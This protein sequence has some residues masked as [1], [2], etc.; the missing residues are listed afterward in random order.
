MPNSTI[1]HSLVRLALMVILPLIAAPVVSIQVAKAQEK[2]KLPLGLQGE[3]AFIPDDNPQTPEKIA[4]GK[5]FFWDKRWSAS[6]TVACV[7]C[8]QPDRGWTDPQQF[9]INFA[10][11]PTPR[12]APTIVN[13]LFSDVQL[14]TGLRASL[15]EQALK[16]LNRTDEKVVE[17]LGSIPAYQQ[18][19]RKI[20]GHDLE[21]IGVAKAIAAYVRTIVSGNSPYDRF[22]AGDKSALS[23]EAQRG[24]ALFEGKAGCVTCHVGFNFT[25][26]NYRNVGVGMDKPNPDLGRYTVT[27]NE[28]EKGAFKTPTLR[29]VARR[30]PYMHDGSEKTLEDLVAFY[31]RGGVNNPW[32]SS[33]IKPLKLTA[34]EQKDLVAFL[35]SL[36]GE[37]DPEVGKPP[38]LPQ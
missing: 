26:E 30:G 20:F 32:L 29:D 12:R 6:G 31:D 13:R 1:I 37:I 23:T 7:S 11:K 35:Q 28:T 22:K 4:L 33:D 19:F 38:T 3:A 27:K 2:L 34:Q 25:D 24:L 36:T 5:K 21:P 16:D 18:E 17:H 15:E 9:S 14:W 10:G 8:H